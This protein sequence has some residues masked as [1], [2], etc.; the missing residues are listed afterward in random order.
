M[1]KAVSVELFTENSSISL[2]NASSRLWA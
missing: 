2:F 1:A